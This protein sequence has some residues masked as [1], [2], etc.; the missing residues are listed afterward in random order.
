MHGSQATDGTAGDGH[1]DHVFP[2]PANT[3]PLGCP[4]A[5]FKTVRALKRMP[6]EQQV[7][8]S[9]MVRLF[10]QHR[11]CGPNGAVLGRC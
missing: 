9:R 7:A 4:S 6:I 8:S 11:T 2:Q 10:V 3:A 5:P 1:G